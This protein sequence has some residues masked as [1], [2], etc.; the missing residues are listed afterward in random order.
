VINIFFAILLY[1]A[2]VNAYVFLHFEINKIVLPSMHGQS[3][4]L[5]TICE[6]DVVM[7]SCLAFFFV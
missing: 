3:L 5:V 7:Y 6:S 4:A 1:D 2:C